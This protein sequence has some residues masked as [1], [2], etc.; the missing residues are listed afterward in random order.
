MATKKAQF[1][2]LLKVAVLL[3]SSI[4]FIEA[5][6]YQDLIFGCLVSDLCPGHIEEA[7]S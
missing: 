5:I 2:F 4:C 6:A 1:L 7:S 3:F